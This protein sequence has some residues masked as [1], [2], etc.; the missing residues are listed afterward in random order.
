MV[1][2]ILSLARNKGKTGIKIGQRRGDSVSLDVNELVS[3]IDSYS[4]E[5][6]HRIGERMAKL[7]VYLTQK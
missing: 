1:N 5:D 4:D 7:G 3:L 6:L 2:E